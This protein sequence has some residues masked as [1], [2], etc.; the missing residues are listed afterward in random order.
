[1]NRARF[2]RN[3]KSLD[4]LVEQSLRKVE[5]MNCVLDNSRLHNDFKDGLGRSETYDYLLRVQTKLEELI[6]ELDYEREM[7]I[8]GYYLESV[9]EIRGHLS[10]EQR[11]LH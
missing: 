4:K 10:E 5:Q 2:L 8:D 6:Y 1:M 11:L 9:P 7:W 3:W